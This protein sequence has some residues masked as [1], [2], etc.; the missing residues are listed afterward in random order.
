MYRIVAHVRDE[1]YPL[2]DLDEVLKSLGELER[3]VLKR[4]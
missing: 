1:E 4:D 3:L 2:E